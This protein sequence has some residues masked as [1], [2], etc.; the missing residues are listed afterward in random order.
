MSYQTYHVH[1]VNRSQ[2]AIDLKAKEKRDF[3]RESLRSCCLFQQY[4][5]ER[6]SATMKRGKMK[7]E[8]KIDGVLIC[9]ETFQMA[10]NVGSSYIDY[11]YYSC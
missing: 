3:V 9:R 4:D 11:R 5:S 10:F 6:Q 8:Y 1:N 7:I 2:S